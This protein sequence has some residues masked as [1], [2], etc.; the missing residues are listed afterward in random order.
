MI[1]YV[2]GNLFTSPAQTL[3][4]T[5]NTEGVMGKGIALTFKRLFPDMFREYH[6]LCVEGKLSIGS[7]QIFRA[8]PKLIVNFPTK[9]TW[10][11][12][13]KPEYI[14][15]GLRTFVSKYDLMGVRSAAFPP[16]GCG[17]GELSFESDVQPLMEKYLSV[18]PI[19]IYIYPPLSKACKPEH[20]DIAEMR[21]WLNDEQRISP[22]AALWS[23]LIE[24][25]R[26]RSRFITL[27]EEVPFNAELVT[28][29]E[30][31]RI[32]V[33]ESGKRY[34]FRREEVEELWAELRHH[35]VL[36]SRSF[37]S[38]K[39]AAS[40]LLPILAGLPYLEPIQ[41]GQTYDD[42]RSSPSYGVRLRPVDDAESSQLALS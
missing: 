40:Y 42:L 34:D 2:T 25:L 23:D 3:V 18:L 28:D 1:Q 13:S 12:P 10:R 27:A 35:L 14:E 19:P 20:Q 22:F 37:V 30:G 36:T 7:L 26:N 4:N 31:E 32:R 5:V 16:L 41:I 9:T 21:R 39:T 33:T 11:R 38:H 24:L 29:V 6:A 8:P 17:N 15:A